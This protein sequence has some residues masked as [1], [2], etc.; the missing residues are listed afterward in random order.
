MVLSYYL[1][2]IPYSITWSVLNMLG[3]TDDV[4]L[5]CANT[6]DY[7]IFSEVQR[8]LP[9]VSVLAKNKKVQQQLRDIGV[10][11]KVYPA[12]PKAV[13]M[14]RQA[15]Y[16]F[17][18]SKITKIGMR[19]GPY[20]FKPFANAKGY[21]LL[22]YFYMTSEDEVERAQ[23][24]GIRCG[25]AK[26]YPKLDPALNGQHDSDFKQQLKQRIG[27]DNDKPTI[28]FTATWD[29]SMVSAIKLWF[30]QLDAFTELYNVLVTVHPW[31]SD[32]IKKRIKSYADVFFID[33]PDVVP[34]I[35]ISDVCIGDTSSILA[36]C[37]AL[38][39]PMVTFK[40]ADG[41]RTVPHVKE[42]IAHFSIQI[43]RIDELAD[44]IEQALCDP[45]SLQQGRQTANQI[46]FDLLDGKAGL[47]T[48]EHIKQV[49]PYLTED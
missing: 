29:K 34:Y 40:V 26:G 32:T 41:K 3:K 27:F 5:Y 31:T 19:H 15:G 8:H 17:P 46:M 1:I 12:F 45:P 43:E 35:G 16:K 22:D 25:V 6:L 9:K 39:K 10:E 7:H 24:A 2:K 20:T 23:K 36:E 37:C 13:I 4:M 18:T 11:A 38:N 47:R 28:L 49:V 48:A 44:A 33:S 21:N 14:C 30:D 42:L